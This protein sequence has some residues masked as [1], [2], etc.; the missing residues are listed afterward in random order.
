MYMRQRYFCTLVPGT[1]NETD[2]L[3][4]NEEKV[5]GEDYIFDRK[6]LERIGIQQRL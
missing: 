6:L 5:I 2:M 3:Q 1:I 4:Y